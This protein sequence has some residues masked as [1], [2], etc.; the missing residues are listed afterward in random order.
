MRARIG[1]SRTVIGGTPL[2]VAARH[3]TRPEVVALLIKAGADVDAK[4]KHGRTPLHRAARSN[5]NPEIVELLVKSGLDV[6]TRNS[7]GRTPLHYAADNGN[8]EVLTVLLEAGANV[9]ARDDSGATPL[10][11]AEAVDKPRNVRVQARSGATGAASS[12]PPA[13][14]EQMPLPRPT[15]R[16]ALPSQTRR[17]RHLPRPGARPECLVR[18]RSDRLRAATRSERRAAEA[19]GGLPS[20]AG[21]L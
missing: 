19:F 10:D 9:N 20:S 11:R 5:E 7:F 17:R 8:P 3:N 16:G 12:A 6:D 2:H 1:K 15:R 14:T 21:R 18:V 4:G 13:A